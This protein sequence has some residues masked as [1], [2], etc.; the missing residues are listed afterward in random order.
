MGYNFSETACFCPLH[1]PAE[2]PAKHPQLYK[3][4]ASRWLNT[5]LASASFLWDDEVMR[6]DSDV[7]SQSVKMGKTDNIWWAVRSGISSFLRSRSRICNFPLLS[8]PSVV[9][10]GGFLQTQGRKNNNNQ[11]KR[12][13]EE[14]IELLD[15]SV[16]DSLTHCQL[17][18][19]QSDLVSEA[20]SKPRRRL[21]KHN[22]TTQQ[23]WQ[24]E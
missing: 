22:K 18:R 21:C 11:N 15:S 6:C 5:A 16:L 9:S 10:S 19:F 14:N 17:A 8:S 24:L 12:K 13:E 23:K 4:A 2:A 3:Q 1:E 20:A 7:K